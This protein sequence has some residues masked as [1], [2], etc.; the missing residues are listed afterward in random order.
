VVRDLVVVAAQIRQ[1]R[2]ARQK[3]LRLWAMEQAIVHPGLDRMAADV[4][5]ALGS[6]GPISS[7]RLNE[8]AGHDDDA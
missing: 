1:V 3:F 8:D 5:A 4:E 2:A 6:A 7:F